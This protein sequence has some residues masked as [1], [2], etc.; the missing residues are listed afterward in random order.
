MSRF[1]LPLLILSAGCGT[2]AS[3]PYKSAY[4]VETIEFL[5]NVTPNSEATTD[6]TK[7]TF[8]DKDGKSVSLSDYLGKQSLVLVVTRGYSGSI[9]PYCATQTSRLISNYPEIKERNAE[10]LVV[11]PLERPGQEGRL[12]EF[13]ERAVS[14]LPAASKKV[15]F[16]LLLDIE[17]KSVEALGIRSNLSK[18][19][20]YIFDKEGKVQFAYVGSSLADRPS[21]KAIL[22]Q[23]DRLNKSAGG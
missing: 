11:Y 9:C 23:L 12:D 15:P 16:P 4:S 1:L 17:L 7:L 3:D 8:T 13:V 20:T 2:T 14:M 10:V 6:F 5:D 21:V 22:S 18:P 19:A